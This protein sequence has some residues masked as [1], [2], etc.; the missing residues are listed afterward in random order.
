ML[1][2]E[3]SGSKGSHMNEDGDTTSRSSR[4]TNHRESLHN[5][6]LSLDSQRSHTSRISLIQAEN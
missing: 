3:D 2:F 5:S 4:A 1:S 6:R